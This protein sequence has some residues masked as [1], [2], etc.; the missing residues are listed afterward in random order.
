MFLGRHWRRW[1]TTPNFGF[2]YGSLNPTTRA[3]RNVFWMGMVLFLTLMFGPLGLLVYLF[4]RQF[5]KA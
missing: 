4:D 1:V 2:G 3:R 5:L